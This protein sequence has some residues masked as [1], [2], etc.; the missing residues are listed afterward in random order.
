MLLQY[1]ELS[2]LLRRAG[3]LAPIPSPFY[4]WGLKTLLTHDQPMSYASH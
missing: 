1:K 2:F 4:A 3:H